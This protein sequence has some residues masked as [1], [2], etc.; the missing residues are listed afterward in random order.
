MARARKLSDTK[1]SL[2][3][4]IYGKFGTRK[5]NM[6]STISTLKKIDGKPL[7]VLYID[8][9]TGSLEGFNKEYLKEQGIDLNNI[10]VVYTS[11]VEELREYSNKFI[12]GEPY[13][14]L[15]EDECETENIVLDSDGN[16][17]IADAIVI[18]GISV[19]AGNVSDAAIELS[20]KRA[21]IKAKRN[22]ATED[23][24][25]VVIGTAGLEFKDHSK[26]KS[27]GKKIVR[28]LINRTDK[29]VVITSRA[30]DK[31]EMEKDSKGNMV[32]VNRGYEI[33]ESWDF[34][35][36]EVFTVIHNVI[37]EDGNIISVIENKD[38]TGLFQQGEIVENLSLSQFQSIID[39]NKGKEDSV[40]FKQKSVE[41]VIEDTKTFLKQENKDTNGSEKSIFKEDSPESLVLKIDEIKS[42]LTPIKRRAVKPVLEK[43]GLPLLYNKD[44]DIDI[45]QKIVDVISTI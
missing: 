23:E 38:R 10:Y 36:Y 7:K 42:G 44:M 13:Y 19:V 3:I 34:I 40:F 21:G 14:E 4:F 45:L 17:F 30:K 25:D 41:D 28:N 11:D 6:A 43:E 18:D 37:D 1:Q 35:Q 26:I 22:N 20:E 8:C 27:I 24:L 16:P 2:K 29:Y 39:K 9:E 32:L 5:S 15:D 33:P 12:N 31:K